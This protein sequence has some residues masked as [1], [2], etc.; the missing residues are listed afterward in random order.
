MMQDWGVTYAELEPY[1]DRFEYCAGISGKAGNLRGVIQD[2]GNPFE[3]PRAR[4]YPTPPMPMTYAPQLFEK[5]AKE[6]GWHPFPQPSAN[7]STAYTNIYG[8][9]MAPCTYCGF[10]ERFGCGNY[11]KASPQTCVLPALVREQNFEARTECQVRR[12]NTTP[13]GRRA[14]GVTYVD[15]QGNAWE[16]PAEIVIVAAYALFNTRMLLLSGIGKPYDPRSGEGVVGRNY[17]YQVSAGVQGF[18]NDDKHFNLFV[19]AGSVG[20]VADDWNDDNFDHSGVGFV[21]GA[22]I[23]CITTNRRP[24]LSRP[25]PPGT[26][27]WGAQWKRATHDW[28][29]RTAAVG[30]QGSVM[31]YRDAWLD[32]DPTYKDGFG[33]PLL[34]MTFDFHD[35]E[36]RMGRFMVDKAEEALKAMGAQT[37]VKT[38]RDRP[39]SIVPYQSTH[40]TGGTIMGEDPRSSVCNKYCQVWD[41]PNVF[42]TG[43]SLFPMN[44]GFNPTGPVGALAY[45]TVDAIRDRY[46]AS[47]DPLVP[48]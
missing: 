15:L 16:Q 45:W 11:S 28:A 29:D 9:R 43:A 2:G 41:V 12:V 4:E 3:G 18:F 40:N 22:S 23:N 31:P 46:L 25:T 14:T 32:L 24:I 1:F 47:P 7:L 27:R 8:C 5:A 10:C 35:N 30:L 17:A 13:D 42:V 37:I 34:R 20:M 26:P 38:Y 33:D 48:Q 36:I 39:Y 21:G 19:G 44:A 6:L